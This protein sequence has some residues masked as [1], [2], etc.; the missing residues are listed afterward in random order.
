MADMLSAGTW[1]F[2]TAFRSGKASSIAPLQYVRLLLM[3]A[4]GYW[5]Y[6]ETPSL[7]TVAGSVLI[8]GAAIYTLHRNAVRQS[9][10]LPDPRPD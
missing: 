3:A 5:L 6:G 9:P 7:A 1:L 2:T 10:I 8:V 4:V